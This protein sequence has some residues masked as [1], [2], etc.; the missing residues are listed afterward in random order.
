MKLKRKVF[1]MNEKFDLGKVVITPN[2][3]GVLN[4]LSIDDAI[5]RH[6]SGD[7]GEMCGEDVQTNNRALKNG[8]RLFSA[9]KDVNDI[10][11]WI[12]TEA[13]RSVTTILLPEDY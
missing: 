2:A 3:M 10:K 8:G 11:F 4:G 7:W 12:I 1:N 13:D 5:E 6:Q 9:Y